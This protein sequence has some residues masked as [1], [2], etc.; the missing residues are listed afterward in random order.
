MTVPVSGKSLT[1]DQR[2][3]VVQVPAEESLIGDVMAADEKAGARTARMA[4]IV[5]A[6]INVDAFAFTVDTFITNFPLEYR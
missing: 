5:N 3:A 1:F 4:D 2:G 6:R